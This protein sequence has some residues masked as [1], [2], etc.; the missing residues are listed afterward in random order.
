[1]AGYIYRIMQEIGSGS[2]GRCFLAQRE[3]GST[4]VK[5]VIKEVDLTCLSPSER[6]LAGNEA[7]IMKQLQHPN[8]IRFFEV[9]K[10][11]SGKMHI[12]MEY[13]ERGNL[14]SF[15][16][17]RAG[18]HLPEEEVMLIVAQLF[19]ALKYLHERNILHRDL[20]PENVLLMEDGT[21]KLSDFGI[22]KALGSPESFTRTQVGSPVFKSPEQWADEEYSFPADIWAAGVMIYELC[23]LQLPFS[24]PN[25]LT[26]AESVRSQ[27]FPPLPAMYSKDL[28]ELLQFMLRKDPATRPPIFQ[29]IRYPL[30]ANYLKNYLSDSI[31]KTQRYPIQEFP[32]VAA[33]PR[34]DPL[35]PSILSSDIPNDPTART[36]LLQEVRRLRAELRKVEL[37]E[38]ET[39]MQ[40]Q[41]LREKVQNYLTILD[42]KEAILEREGDEVHV[43]VPLV[44]LPEARPDEDIPEFPELPSRAEELRQQ[45]RSNLGSDVF[46]EVY[47]IIA[48]LKARSDFTDYGTS[49]YKSHLLHILPIPSIV[50][51][52]PQFKLLLSLSR[53]SK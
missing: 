52:V 39:S 5:C 18:V 46:D 49:S 27:P 6:M 16:M 42:V 7:N 22:S 41:E 14:H 35:P 31:R 10:T 33:L 37:P 9:Y 51:Y 25:P 47:G 21:V 36:C 19:L 48:T 30:I 28:A 32:M 3:S 4:A 15:V 29:L 26:L 13:A 20:K 8:I 12:V 1:M 45:L 53:D 34:I 23:A 38:R 24:S 40:V 44:A 2:F 43:A 17:R 50:L 11:R